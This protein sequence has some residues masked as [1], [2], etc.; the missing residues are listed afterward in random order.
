MVFMPIASHC[1]KREISGIAFD[2]L[3]AMYVGPTSTCTVYFLLYFK[4]VLVQYKT[5]NP[6]AGA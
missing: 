5:F 2:T 4:L 1:S 3:R 6:A